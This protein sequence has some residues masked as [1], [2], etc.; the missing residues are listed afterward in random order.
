MEQFRE[1]DVVQLKSGGPLMTISKLG[2]TGIYCDW[3]IKDELKHG[4]FKPYQLKKIDD[5]E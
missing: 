3:F 5:E 1:G 2:E 4:V